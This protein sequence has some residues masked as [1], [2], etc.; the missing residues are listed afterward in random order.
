LIIFFGQCQ[1]H[2]RRKYQKIAHIELYMG[3]KIQVWIFRRSSALPRC[4]V[5]RFSSAGDFVGRARPIPKSPILK[6]NP[7]TRSVWPDPKFEIP[8]L[9]IY[10]KK[11][12]W[13][14]FRFSPVRTKM[15]FFRESGKNRVRVWPIASEKTRLRDFLGYF[16]GVAAG[17]SMVSC[18]FTY[19]LFTKNQ[20]VQKVH[21]WPN[22]KNGVFTRG[23][24]MVF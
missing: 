14:F 20:K 22:A 23:D 11:G 4:T 21:F 3:R 2:Y 8:N 13:L 16:R 12:L 5:C 10:P 18:F 17:V 9:Q 15:S 7:H 24:L 19:V 1:S 6:K